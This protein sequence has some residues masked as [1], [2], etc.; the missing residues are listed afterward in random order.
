[1][2]QVSAIEYC[3]CVFTALAQTAGCRLL[4]RSRESSSLAGHAVLPEYRGNP[5]EIRNRV[6]MLSPRLTFNEVSTS[7]YCV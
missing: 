5:R 1:M 6:G 2:I 7:L 3:S 4:H